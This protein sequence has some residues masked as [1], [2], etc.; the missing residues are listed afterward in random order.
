MHRH[1][2]RLA[3]AAGDKSQF[4]VF[5]RAAKLVQRSRPP[6]LQP[7][8]SRTKEYLRDEVATRTIE[9]LAFITRDLDRVLDFGA[10]SGNFVKALC[11]QLHPPPDGDD[12]DSQICAQ[13]NT[14]KER[15]R[16]KIGELV[17]MDLSRAM[18]YRDCAEKWDHAFPGQ[19]VRAV[20]DEEAF[21]HEC[22]RDSEQYDAV[23]L[24]LLMHWINDLPQTLKNI[25]RVLKPDGLFMG[26]LFGG[27]TLYE[28][29]TLLQLAELERRGGM[30]A[31]VSPLVHLNDIG[32]LLNRAGFSMLT[33]DQEEIVIGGYPDIVAVM[34]D[35]Q[36]MGEQ[37]A[38]NTRE[39][40]LPREVLLAANEI[41]K[42]LH[43]EVHDGVTTLPATVNVIF[44]I[45]WKKS[46]SQ[47]KPLARGTGQV[48]LK[49][50]LEKQTKQ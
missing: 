23:V 21:A 4:N 41:Y 17:M 28:L 26:T 10:H 33:I 42:L 1:I 14:D 7:D 13:L 22:V 9:R 48:N 3:T 37:N 49:D 27:D 25:N 35:L 39:L 32:S 16:N 38:V 29:R 19:V 45:G 47:P 2:R 6:L 20:G 44:M 11:T 43:G 31:R 8:R 12:V 46:D 15:I 5:D 40:F 30:A 50:V 24:N 34:E 36:L 18:L